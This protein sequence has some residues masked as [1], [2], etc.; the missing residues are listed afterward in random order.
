MIIKRNI[1]NRLIEEFSVPEVVILLG[2]R[3]VGKTHLLE[4]LNKYAEGQGFKTC[5]KLLIILQK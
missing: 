5:S 2:A 3:Q 1:F 4:R